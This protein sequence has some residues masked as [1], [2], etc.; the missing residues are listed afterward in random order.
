MTSIV[1]WRLSES[2]SKLII[3]TYTCGQSGKIIHN[4]HSHLH[5]KSEM[6]IFVDDLYAG[7]LLIR[8]TLIIEMSSID[9]AA[10][11]EIKVPK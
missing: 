9:C 6:G 1:T 11:F 5:S 4:G 2:L 10:R 7:H 3:L 8:Y